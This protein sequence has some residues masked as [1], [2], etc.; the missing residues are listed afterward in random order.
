MCRIFYLLDNVDEH[1]IDD[2]WYVDESTAEILPRQNLKII[3][4]PKWNAINLKWII[5]I[6]SHTHNSKRNSMNYVFH[7]YQVRRGMCYGNNILNQ[8][9]G[10]TEALAGASTTLLQCIIL[11]ENR[12]KIEKKCYFYLQN[13]IYLFM[14]AIQ[15]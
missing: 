1:Y 9:M 2:R 4:C 11:D 5:S 13:L 14:I 15:Q 3:I 7:V 6:D 10:K 12:L 8:K